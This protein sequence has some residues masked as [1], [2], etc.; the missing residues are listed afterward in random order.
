MIRPCRFV[1]YIDESGDTGLHNVRPRSPSGASEWLILSCFLIRA[2]RDSSV[3][4]WV[5][6]IKGQF[7]NH[8]RPDL[9]YSALIPV[10]KAIA[11]QALATKPCRLFVVMS[12][13]RNIEGYRNPN[14]DDGNKAWLYWFMARLL[15]ER[16]TE[17]CHLATH[18]RER[19]SVVLRIVFSRRGGLRYIDFVNYLRK[20]QRQSR[21]GMLVLGQGDLTWSLID[22]DEI[23][24]LDHS[25]R[26]GLQLAD[27]GAAAFFQ[28]VERNRPA[29]CDP[30]Y[31]KMLKG[32]VARRGRSA[33]S[34]GI[35][36]MPELSSMDLSQQQREIFEFYGFNPAGW[37]APGG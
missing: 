18:D 6:E 2:E 23:R 1:A 20:L 31:A 28:A 35:K 10:K 8:Q 19:G 9:H 7:R 4:T 34:F 11:C 29:E 13:K 30:Q 33:L 36:T 25:Q 26:A 3:P 5:N 16:V 24:V 12:N 17:Y 15:L 22:F 37:R 32:V 21:A 14:L 27:I